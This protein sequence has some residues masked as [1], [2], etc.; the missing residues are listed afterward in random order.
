M[1][2]GR[3][4][5]LL[6]LLCALW[7]GGCATPDKTTPKLN[8]KVPPGWKEGSSD[9]AGPYRAGWLADF[10]S[11][12]LESLVSEAVK[13]NY[14]LQIA[15]ARM[16]E[17][18]AQA[19]IAGA[20]LYPSLNASLNASHT[21]YP[22]QRQSTGGN[23]SQSSGQSGNKTINSFGA[24]LNLSWE[25]DLWGQLRSAKAAA[26]AT[27]QAAV[28]DR[29]AAR[30]SLAAQTAKAWFLVLESKLQ[31]QNAQD[32]V[33]SFKRTAE[34][35]DLRYKNGK[36]SKF[37]VELATANQKQAESS[38]A[39][40]QEEF[41]AAKRSLEV[42][43]GRYPAGEVDSEG[44]LPGLASV[45]AGVPS[46]VLSRR[47]DLRAEEWR[48][49]SSE[50]SVFSAKAQRYPRISLTTST[51]STSDALRNLF[52]ENNLF[53]TIV[54]NLTQPIFEGGA[55]S[56]QIELSEAQ[57]KE[58]AATYAKLVLNAFKEVEDALNLEQSLVDQEKATQEAYDHFTQAYQIA[59]NRYKYGQIDIL[60]ILDSQRSMLQ[61]Q[62]DVLT[63]KL[64]RLNIRVDLLLAL[65]GD[66]QAPKAD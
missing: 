16:E 40:R 66:Y 28:F 15:A 57:R 54:G 61:A 50:N 33:D 32:T 36:A 43:L 41:S 42:L 20:P 51:G 7:L 24:G 5:I 60:S 26:S 29:D 23:S 11:D 48:L 65:G 2:R 35:S 19:R 6:F 44:A 55:I 38:L 58:A 30:F 21:E 53:W 13:N 1:N 37:D 31:I 14:D 47:P 22:W 18:A 8:V 52:N 56:G 59:N 45:P 49:F 9:T 25:I 34:Y 17:A 64:A 62:R 10:E 27:A 63:V 39:Q 12:H 46:E 3:P 4:L